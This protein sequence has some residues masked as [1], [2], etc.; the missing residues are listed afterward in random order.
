MISFEGCD[1]S[2]KSTQLQKAA[3][4]LR[5]WGLDVV[6]T[7]EPGGT[8]FGEAVRKVLLD[9]KGPDRGALSELFLY[10]ASR[11]QLVEQVILPALVKGQVVLTERFSDSS[12]VYQGFAG[13]IP[14]PT[15]ETINRIATRD[16]APDLTFVFD[17]PDE[18][19]F[20]ERL[21]PKQRDKI[22]LRD[23]SYH[24]KVRQG[25]RE[26]A[27]RFPGRIRLIDGSL[28]KEKVSEIVKSEMQEF[29]KQRMGGNFM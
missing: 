4:S 26:L 18:K 11:A 25:Y 16:L 3:S 12:L 2:G 27:E 17:V 7:R 6:V 24:E 13:G 5:E 1:G 9:P 20:H 10:A 15:I 21:M 23:D 22:E 29:I 19:V 28:S 14:L 8:D